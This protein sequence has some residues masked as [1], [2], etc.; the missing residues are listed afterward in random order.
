MEAYSPHSRRRVLRRL[1]LVGLVAVVAG[2]LAASAALGQPAA[3]RPGSAPSSPLKTVGAPS[4]RATYVDIYW[5]DGTNET[6]AAG[7]QR[8][9][10]AL[11]ARTLT[12]R[13]LAEHR[14][15]GARGAISPDASDGGGGSTACSWSI[16]G[17]YKASSTTAAVDAAVSCTWDVSSVQ[18]TLYLFRSANYTIIGWDSESG[19]ANVVWG[20][21]GG[22]L[23]STWQYNAELVYSF[24]S[25][26]NG[27]HY[28]PAHWNG[29]IWITC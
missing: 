22:C 2:L 24:V 12:Q 20:T 10:S 18:G 19:G 21:S 8:P 26:V 27:A 6:V 28:P 1:P 14:L 3:R 9:S 13:A 23:S 15:G 25:D 11:A 4:I 5:A 16:Y 17:P 29:P 7:R